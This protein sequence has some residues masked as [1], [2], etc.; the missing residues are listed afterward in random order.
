M[1]YCPITYDPLEPNELYSAKG[2]RQLSPRLKMLEPLSYSAQEQ[3]TEAIN[4]ATKLS[5]QGV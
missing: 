3:R 2:L 1:R 5:I 4:R